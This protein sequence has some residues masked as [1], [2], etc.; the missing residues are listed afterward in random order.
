MFLTE[1]YLDQGTEI[2]LHSCLFLSGSQSN[3]ERL[4]EGLLKATLTHLQTGERTG[5][6]VAKNH[7]EKMLTSLPRPRSL[8]HLSLSHV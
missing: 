2:Y 8:G 1:I 5:E 3:F 4:S 6:K 7:Q